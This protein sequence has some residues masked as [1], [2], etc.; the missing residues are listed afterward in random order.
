LSSSTLLMESFQC[1]VRSTPTLQVWSNSSFSTEMCWFL[2][3][4]SI[5]TLSNL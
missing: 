1:W 5:W 3:F 2:L 4:H